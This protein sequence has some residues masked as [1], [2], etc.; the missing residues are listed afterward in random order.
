MRI[1]PF[2]FAVLAI[3]V[4]ESIASGEGLAAP[5]FVEAGKA[6]YISSKIVYVDAVNRRSGIRA[7]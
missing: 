5:R 1:L 3:G 6:R 7:G 2:I 4:S